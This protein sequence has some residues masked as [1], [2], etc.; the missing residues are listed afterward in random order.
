MAFISTVSEPMAEKAHTDRLTEVKAQ[1]TDLYG[2]RYDVWFE[3]RTRP[4]GLRCP[5]NPNC[6]TYYHEGDGKGDM[7][8]PALYTEAITLVCGTDKVDYN[9]V[10]E[11][12][13]WLRNAS[14][15]F[16]RDYYFSGTIL[17]N[18]LLT[19]REKTICAYAFIVGMMIGRFHTDIIIDAGCIQLPCLFPELE[20]RRKMYLE[21]LNCQSLSV[22]PAARAIIY[23][24]EYGRPVRDA[25]TLATTK[26]WLVAKTILDESFDDANT[27]VSIL[28]D[29]ES[30]WK[31]R[32]PIVRAY[33][34]A[35]A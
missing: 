25:A 24:R 12:L 23:N 4:V 19:P 29:Y 8:L 5:A 17:K 35:L 33:E 16:G 15:E 18:N 10:I 20:V 9:A 14:K 26:E 30:S 7:P 13:V 11:L 28:V 3:E 1:I 34:L 6:W 22:I 31:R 27:I 2:E 32:G 21:S